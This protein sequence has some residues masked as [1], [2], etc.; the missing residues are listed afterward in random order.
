[1]SA[2]M[3]AKRSMIIPE[4]RWIQSLAPGVSRVWRA[5]APMLRYHAHRPRREGYALLGRLGRGRTG[6][7]EASCLKVPG[8][9][10]QG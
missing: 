10:P 9:R 5:E 6:G 3:H 8:A 7:R 2:K 4:A 1:M